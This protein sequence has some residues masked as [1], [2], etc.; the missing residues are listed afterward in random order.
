MIPFKLSALSHTWFIDLDGTILRHN[1]H[2]I[3][4]DVILSGVK[5]LWD[6]IPDDDYIVITTGRAVEYKDAT[7]KLLQENGLRYNTALFELPMGERI[8]INDIKPQGLKTAIAWNIERNKGF[9]K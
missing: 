5:E 1:G 7:L 9:T 6:T 2:L 4:D 3:G 8:I